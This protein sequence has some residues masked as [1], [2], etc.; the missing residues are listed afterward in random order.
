MFLT[1][2]SSQSAVFLILQFS[3]PLVFLPSLSWKRDCDQISQT[4]ANFCSCVLSVSWCVLRTSRFYLKT[5]GFALSADRPLRFFFCFPCCVCRCCSA[6]GGGGGGVR[7]GGLLLHKVQIVFSTFSEV[8]ICHR[9]KIIV[10]S[11]FWRHSEFLQKPS[12]AG[13]IPPH[14]FFFMPLPCRF[15]HVCGQAHIA[16]LSCRDAWDVPLN[17]R[18]SSLSINSF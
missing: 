12:P 9:T 10:S 5:C 14:F 16:A 7:R 18:E 2:F 6:A 4:D 11:S 13:S 3:L 15:R 17:L 1:L 8:C